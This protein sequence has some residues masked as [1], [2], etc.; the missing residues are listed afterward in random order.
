MQRTHNWTTEEW[1]EAERKHHMRPFSDYAASKTGNP[2]IVTRAEGVYTF[3]TEGN[4][5][6]DG[7]AGLW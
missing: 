5:V 6:L 2:R 4:K 1:V 7:M 3:D